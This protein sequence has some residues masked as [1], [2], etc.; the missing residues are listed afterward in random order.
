MI[1][2]PPSA[3]RGDGAPQI[4]LRA[5]DGVRIAATHLANPSAAF[6]L[7]V[8]HGNAEDLAAMGPWLVRVRQ[9][10]FS[11]FA[12]DYRG[13]GHSEGRPSERGTYAAVD[14]AYADLERG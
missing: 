13:Y 14:A 4:T 6:T 12:Y 11:V 10:G 1:F 9:I 5:A 7:L 3:T 8:S 2:V